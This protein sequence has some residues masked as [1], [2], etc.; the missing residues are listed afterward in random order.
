[1]FSFVPCFQWAVYTHVLKQLVTYFK[2]LTNVLIRWVEA[3][4]FLSFN[5]CWS[6]YF[7]IHKICSFRQV[8]SRFMN[9]NDLISANGEKVSEM[10]TTASISSDSN[11][12]FHNLYSEPS[13]ITGFGRLT[14]KNR[15][16]YFLKNLS[17]Y[18]FKVVQS[19]FE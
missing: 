11:Y 10:L 17:S 4:K 6:Y 5:T 1:M 16:I 14:P 2:R 13:E 7:F 18:K 8:Q 3:C 19:D 12:V 9:V 15:G